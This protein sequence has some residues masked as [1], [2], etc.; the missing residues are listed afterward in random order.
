MK[1]TPLQARK[2][3]ARRTAL[4]PVNRERKQRRQDAGEVY[5]PYHIWLATLPCTV[6]NRDCWGPVAGHHL[7]TVAAGGKDADGEIC[8]C[9]S[10]HLEVHTIGRLL[11][12]ARHHID[13][14]LAAARLRVAYG[15][16][17]P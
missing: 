8:L 7:K 16:R 1:R 14:D 11:F 5:G 6:L 13:L 17:A 10:H 3:L 9:A 4:N 2:A 12:E 15:R